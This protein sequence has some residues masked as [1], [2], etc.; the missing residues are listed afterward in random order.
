MSVA[1]TG[2]GRSIAQIPQQVGVDL[3]LG[4]GPAGV[5]PWVHGPQAELAHQATNASATHP[6]AFAF[7]HHLHAPAAVH[8]VLGEDRVQ[9]LEQTQR[10]RVFRFPPQKRD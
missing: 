4:M 1:H 9:A 8:R 10:L 7:E 6:Y 3:V 5:G 2:L